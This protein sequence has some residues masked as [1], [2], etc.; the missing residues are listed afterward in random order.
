MRSQS[1]E[2]AVFWSSFDEIKLDTFAQA[3]WAGPSIPLHLNINDSYCLVSCFLKQ[4]L[5]AKAV[6]TLPTR[7]HECMS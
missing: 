6:S 2:D 5:I 4:V 1:P 7:V 3:P